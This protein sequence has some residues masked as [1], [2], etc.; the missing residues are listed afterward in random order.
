MT[1]GW[2]H[3]K[4]LGQRQLPRSAWPWKTYL[5]ACALQLAATVLIALGPS[6]VLPLPTWRQKL[7]PVYYLVVGLLVG[8]YV[9][10]IQFLAKA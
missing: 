4:W 1:E 5:I 3:A 7:P 6:L 2:M 10:L 9:T 8:S